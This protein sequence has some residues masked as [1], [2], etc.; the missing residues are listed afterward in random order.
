[1]KLNELKTKKITMATVK[2]FIAKSKNLYIEKI[3]DFNGMSDMVEFYDNNKLIETTQENALGRDGIWTVGR[4]NDF[5]KFME[6]ETHYGIKIFNS[7]GSGIIW[8]KK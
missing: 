5:F 4:G 8:T 2:S 1:M 3:S 6:S 7:C